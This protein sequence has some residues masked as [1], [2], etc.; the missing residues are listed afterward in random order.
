MAQITL[1]KL[2]ELSGLSI[3]TV[4]RVL[5]NQANVVP[6]KRELVLKLA[7]QYHYLPNMAARNLRLQKKNFVGILS[8]N[9]QTEVF[10]QK[11]NDLERRLF[12]AGYYPIL[13]RPDNFSADFLKMMQD[14]SG[15]MDYVVV[16]ELPSRHAKVALSDFPLDFIFVDRGIVPE[17]HSL[18][19]DRAGGVSEAIKHLLRCG[20]RKILHCGTQISRKEGV[21]R[22]FDELGGQYGAERL[23]LESQAEFID[24]YSLG[25]TILRYNPDALF[26]DTDR[27][28]AGFLKYAA[29]RRISIPDDI[30][31]V[32][33]DDD[34]ICRMSAPA[35]SSVAH[36]IAEIN[37]EI[38]SILTNT[39]EKK[40]QKTF[41]TRFVPRESC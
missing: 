37:S 21:Q 2:S 6:E 10:L 7:E 33:F 15:V 35:L 29:E 39:P 32:G 4:S 9:F 40:V 34:L 5:K 20:R 28:A 19:I 16:F 26:F 24:G 27:M 14:W 23:F 41:P 3:R 13:G 18:L 25:P 36:P 22:A 8:S 38:V 31:V 12:S 30:A 17:H 1:K 11:V